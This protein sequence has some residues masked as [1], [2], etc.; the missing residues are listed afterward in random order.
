MENEKDKEKETA[1]LKH[2]DSIF[3][4]DTLRTIKFD[5][6]PMLKALFDYFEEFLY[7]P[8]PKYDKLRRQH[9]EISDLLEKSFNEGQ[10][11]LFEKYWE[12]GCEMDLEESEQLFYFGYII[13]KKLE[14]ESK[15]ENKETSK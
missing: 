15:I 9:I 2:F 8:S 7:K 10:Q 14:Q 12:V 1:L 5:N 13:A 3:E 6:M 11:T 4:T